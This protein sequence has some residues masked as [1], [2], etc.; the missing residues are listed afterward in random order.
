MNVK[1]GCNLKEK[2]YAHGV[3]CHN[4]DL[5]ATREVAFVMSDRPNKLE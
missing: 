5:F 3:A 1:F 4:S 2:S